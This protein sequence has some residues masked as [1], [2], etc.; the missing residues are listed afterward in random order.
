MKKVLKRVLSTLLTVALLLSA[1]PL[2]GLYTPFV[3]NAS[4]METEENSYA[5]LHNYIDTLGEK[6][7][8]DYNSV[9]YWVGSFD[10]SDVYAWLTNDTDYDCIE[11]YSEIMVDDY[12]STWVYL[13]VGEYDSTY[14]MTVGCTAYGEDL[15]GYCEIN[16]KKFN[17]EKINVD[18]ELVQVPFELEDDQYTAYEVLESAIPAS[19]YSIELALE[20]YAYLS[21]G[22][23]GF[24]YFD[25]DIM[26]VT[27]TELNGL[28]RDNYGWNYY[29]DNEINTEFMGVAYNC[30]GTWL[31]SDGTID[32]G[33]TGIFNVYDSEYDIS[34]DYVIVD[35][36]AVDDEGL[37]KIDGVWY[38]NSYGM[39]DY[40]YE[41]LAKNQYGWWYVKNG[42]IDFSY[43]GMARN[44]YGWWYVN[45]GKLNKS[46][47]GLAKN[48]YGWWYFNKGS[49]DYKFDGLAKNQYGWW[50]IKNGTINYK[51][52]GLAKNQY[53]W[54]Y[55]K[56][57]TIDF[58][59]NGTASNKYGTWK[60]VN[61][62]VVTK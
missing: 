45:N 20:N 53:G 9:G 24:K 49:I 18:I 48:Q 28:F 19:I 47:T 42:T 27:T 61:G 43:T 12:S 21:L 52:K 55:V 35:G 17:P 10:D 33:Y 36:K 58:S 54:W 51:F 16:P 57:G 44:E 4:A 60:V 15:I 34:E 2:F 8:N 30:F 46:Y 14:S 32:F 26:Y 13:N 62:K 40:S 3:S 29:E 37:I 23:F 38:Y 39:I 59:Y 1:A 41:G 11:L 50:Y 25:E 5:Y 6:D 31:V 56:N 7:E 22:N